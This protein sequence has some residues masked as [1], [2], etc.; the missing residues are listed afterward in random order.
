MSLRLA[1]RQ[2]AISSRRSWKPQ[3]QWLPHGI[4]CYRDFSHGVQ[5][6]ASLFPQRPITSM[7][8]NSPPVSHSHSP[9]RRTFFTESLPPALI[10]PTIFLM[11]F[12]GLWSYKVIMTIVFQNKIIYMP[13]MPPFA[14]SE[15]MEDYTQLCRPVDWHEI[16]IRSLDGTRIALCVGE[17]Q[18]GRFQ[19]AT[20]EKLRPKRT[21]I[22]YFQGNGGSIPLRLPMLSG[23][24][25]ALNRRVGEHSMRFTLVAPSYRGFWKSRGRASQRGIERDAKATLEWVR[26]AYGNDANIVLWGQSLGAGVAANLAAW[27]VNKPPA[28]TPTHRSKIAGMILE[29]PFIGIKEMLLA[30]Y[31]QKWLPYR[32]LWPFLRNFWDSDE[33]L[34]EIAMSPRK[35]DLPIQIITAGS[36][37]VVPANQADHLHILCEDLKLDVRRKDIT[38]S[39][40]NEVPDR[41]QGRETIAAFIS[42]VGYR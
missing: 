40:H 2:A 14:R 31:P 17:I 10:P 16:S 33:A 20:P 6:K 28:Q 25:K 19:E 1:A 36:D 9:C 30:L 42:E 26:Q 27:H 11:C 5:L 37:E 18:R 32:Y 3:S 8:R 15:K 39:L 41:V 24:L 7:T 12:L 13:Y 21:V 35:M 22:I 4:K 29:T 38:G 23:V 34:R